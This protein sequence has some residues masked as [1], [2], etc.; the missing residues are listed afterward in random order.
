MSERTIYSWIP[1]A[2]SFLFFISGNKPNL[3][4]GADKTAR[5]LFLIKDLRFIMKIEH[6]AIWVDDLERMREFYSK[7]FS[8]TAGEK[9][10]NSTKQYTSYF[11]QF[12][13]DKTRLELMHKPG[14]TDIQG[15]R[16]LQKGITHFAISV[17]SKEKVDT[18]TGILRKENYTIFSEPRTT[19]DGYYESVILDPE[20]NQ[21]EITV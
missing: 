15:Q 9:Y 18:L 6:L 10:S 2:G 5:L 8:M 17:G 12:D 20:G 1:S 7:Y 16:G 13:G 11:L 3:A 21:V 14:I 4:I 19:G